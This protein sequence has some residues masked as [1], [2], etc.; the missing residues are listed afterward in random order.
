MV[1]LLNHDM[2]SFWL[3]LIH[4]YL[5]CRVVLLLLLIVFFEF[6]VLMMPHDGAIDNGNNYKHDQDGGIERYY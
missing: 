4:F 3:S 1:L 2:L 6:K 5:I